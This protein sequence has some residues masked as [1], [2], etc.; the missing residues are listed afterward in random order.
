M[1][2]Y[3]EDFHVGQRFSPGLRHTV[4][5]E[6]IL[7]FASEFDPQP[8]HLD[9]AAARATPFGGLVASGWH[10]A[11]LAMKLMVQGLVQGVASLGSPGV[12]E[13]RWLVPVRPDDTLELQVEVV[14]KKPSASRPDRGAVTLRC[15]LYNQKNER[16]MTMQSPGIIRRRPTG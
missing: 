15:E 11:S 9:D 1:T 12:D 4:T 2:L 6:A 8:F 7:R 10:T 5:R 14:A 3:F 16:V 13:L